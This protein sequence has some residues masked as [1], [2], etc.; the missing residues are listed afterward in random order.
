MSEWY[1]AKNDEQHGPVAIEV[2]VDLY[3]RGEINGDSLIWCEG[4]PD[5]QPLAR[6]R[7]ALGLA[8]A[9][10]APS[11]APP[12]PPA[13]PP[14]TAAAVGEP[15]PSRASSS[16]TGAQRPQASPYAP[17]TAAPPAQH[18]GASAAGHVVQAGFLRRWA[19]LIVD[20]LILGAALV[21][22]TLIIAIPTGLFSAS[23]PESASIVQIIYYGFYLLAAPIY[24]AGQESS[25]AQATLGKR[26]IGI[27]VVDRDGGQLSFMHALGRWFA[28]SLSYLTMYIGFLMAAFTEKKQALHDLIAG[29]YV[30]DRWAYTDRPELQKSGATG[31]L[32]IGLVLLLP[33]I[34]V[35]GILAAIAIPAYQDYTQ[36]VHVSQVIA[37]VAPVKIAIEEFHASNDRCPNDWDELQMSA[38]DSNYVS[39]TLVGYNAE[40]QCVIQVTFDAVGTDL[41]TIGKRLWM[42]RADTGSWKCSSELDN[43]Y[44][45]VTCR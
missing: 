31:C 16:A 14:S 27:K 4:M 44:L 42:V 20:S 29:T 39:E 19:A 10:I 35:I 1:Y 15:T 38:P 26:I 9:P 36:R 18:A 11:S 2:L 40:S 3:R 37:D 6:H 41:Q 23:S 17:P 25:A 28:A 5:W 8:S 22:V 24:Y 32:V 7:Q 43:R 12:P 21:T 34:A 30:V 33:L 13:P 45:P